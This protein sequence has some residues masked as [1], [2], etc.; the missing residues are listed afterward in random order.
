M[1]AWG[2]SWHSSV[3][4]LPAAI[5]MWTQWGRMHWLTGRSRKA[6]APKCAQYW[7]FWKTCWYRRSRTTNAR[8]LMAWMHW[9]TTTEEGAR[10][11]LRLTEPLNSQDACTQGDVDLFRLWLSSAIDN[12]HQHTCVAKDSY[13]GFTRSCPAKPANRAPVTPPDL[14]AY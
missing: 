5:V 12:T 11:L 3:L 10:R 14:R 2:R 13:V 1:L 9:L 4:Y 7:Q 8:L 6:F